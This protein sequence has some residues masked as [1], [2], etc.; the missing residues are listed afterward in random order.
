MNV[1]KSFTQ[2]QAIAFQGLI[3]YCSSIKFVEVTSVPLILLGNTVSFN[4]FMLLCLNMSS[5]SYLLID[6][7]KI[8]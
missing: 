5:L 1:A 4:Y 6:I 7:R 2:S 8:R 3:R